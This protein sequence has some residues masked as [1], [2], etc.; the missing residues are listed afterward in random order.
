[1]QL[2]LQARLV[3]GLGLLLAIMMML[4]VASTRGLADLNLHAQLLAQ[5]NLP[6]VEA[7]SAVERSLSGVRRMELLHVLSVEGKDMDGYE[8][9]YLTRKQEFEEAV[10]VC[11]PLVKT[12][13][14][15]ELFDKATTNAARYLEISTRA[16]AASREG[17]KEEAATLCRGEGRAIF[18]DVAKQLVDLIALQTRDGAEEAKAAAAANASARAWLFGVAAAGFALSVVIGIV[19]IRSIRRPIGQVVQTLEAVA[20]RD[21][22]RPPL[23]LTVNDEI[24]KLARATDKM[25]AALKG[26]I[27]KVASTSDEVAAASTQVAASAEELATTVREQEQ[28]T[29][30]VASAVAELSASVSEVAGKAASAS[31]AA[32]DS[33][34]QAD[35]GGQLVGQT[36]NQLVEIN[37]RFNDVAQVV[38]KLEQ[39][40][41]EVGRIV[42]VIQD[43]ADQ[44]NLLALNAAIEAAR[45]GEHGR[46]F[47]VVADEVRKLAERTTHATSEV[48]KTI[49]AMRNGTNE[50]AAAMKVGRETVEQGRQMGVKAGDSVRVIVDAQ[51]G[52]ESMSQSIAAAA[53]QQ[54]SATEEIARSLE[55]MNAANGQSASAASQ[56]AQAAGGLSKKAEEL[57]QLVECFKV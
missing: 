18:R 11:K 42:Q 23:G 50:A 38:G 35:S 10:K 25:S 4:V 28:T 1:M 13:E 33:R 7:A 3:V 24:G 31:K 22:T 41:D 17:R 21:L 49:E 32:A 54:A 36:V 43:I 8:K 40:G 53:Q 19:L 47:A 39:Q 29:T 37:S 6:S 15:R 30:Q 55:T 44:T 48:G 45:A 12:T 2:P 14:E 9:D 56:S 16:I 27:G 5:D 51:R 34:A 57:K 52:A 46:G 20:N 26:M